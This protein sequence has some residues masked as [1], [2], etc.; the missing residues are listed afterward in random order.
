[1][2][3][4]RPSGGR[5]VGADPLGSLARLVLRFPVRTLALTVC[6]LVVAAVAGAGVG[7]RLYHGGTT[8]PGAESARAE[9]VLTTAFRSGGPTVTLVATT[10]GSVDDPAAVRAGTRLTALAR[11]LPKVVAVRSYWPERIAALRGRDGDAAMVLLRVATSEATAHQDV[12]PLLER[13][14]GRRG[15]LEVSATGPTP[16][17]LAIERQ[18]SADLRRMELLAAPLTAAVLVVVFGGVV[19]AGVALLVGLAAV[20][21][22]TAVLS[23][24]AGLTTVSVIALN[25]TT[26]LGFALAVDFSLFVLARYREERARSGDAHDALVETVRTTGRTVVCSALTV[27]GSMAALLVFPLDMLRSI[28]YGGMAVV[29]LSALLAI[30]ALPA[31][32]LL[33]GP[34]IDRFSLRRRVRRHGRGGGRWYRL[35]AGVMR[36]PVPVVLALGTLLAV[37]VLPFA[38]ARFGTFDDRALPRASTTRQATETLRREFDYAALN[39]VQVVLP[40]LDATDRRAGRALDAYARDLSRLEHVTRVE[41]VTGIYRDG[42]PVDAVDP[43]AGFAVPAGT[44]AAVV[45]DIGPHAAEGARLV[46]AVRAVAAP[47]P[48]LVGGTQA[49]LADLQ[50]SIRA[51]LVPALSLITLVTLGLLGWC[52]RS[53]V[54]PLKA[55][56]LNVLSLSATFGVMVLV[57]QQG[58]L[59]EW[60]GGFTVTGVTDTLVP[61]LVLCVAFGLSMDYEVLLLSRTVEE[62]AAGASTRQAVA[63]AVQR[64]A[65]LF[66]ASAVVVIVVMSALA[67]SGLLLLKVVGVSVAVAVFVDATLIRLLLAPALM[68]LLGRANWWLPV[69]RSPDPPP[70]LPTLPA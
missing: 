69:R 42:R 28:A 30:T 9:K 29:A 58:F 6:A 38:D 1:M 8:A 51:G 32:L 20:V 3:S 39:P 19:A 18:S 52:T 49:W 40:G 14:T 41:T 50:D 65:G 25:L 56:L 31:A 60:L 43:A 54:L 17:G 57:F 47:V 46:R 61:V 7:E 68:A 63:R 22:S 4:L 16:V 59:S 53:V 36:R 44:W 62:H 13:L 2:P 67:A 55:F 27:I 35:A 15:P 48:V 45:T 34:R 10:A 11:G 12:E 70:P 66:T 37:L 33:L 26:A 23:A 24:L 64:T 21:G 5:P